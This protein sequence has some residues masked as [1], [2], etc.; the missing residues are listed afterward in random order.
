MSRLTGPEL[1][2]GVVLASGGL[3][4]VLDATIVAVALPYL[5]GTFGATLAAAQWIITAYTLA[6]VATMPLAAGL[7]A[8]WGARRVYLGALAAFAAASAVA[9]A[10]DGLGW[11]IAARAAQGLGGGLM[12]PLGMA[13][14][15]GAVAPE[16]RGRMMAITG[17]PMLAGPILG[18]VL[19]AVLLGTGSWRALFFVT[20]PLALL[21]IAGALAWLP[22]DGA[23]GRRTRLDLAG[24]ML[25][26]PGIVAVAY[27]ISAH[28]APGWV[29]IATAAAGAVLA[30]VFCVRAT[31]RPEP[32]LRIG[33]LGRPGF[34]R[35]AAVLA[36]Y[37][38]PYFGSAVLMPAYV[39]TLRS[40]SPAI[41][42]A[43]M[44]PG[45]IG[46]G[47]SLQIAA[48]LLERLG[49]RLVVG[50]GLGLAIAAGLAQVAVLRPDTPYA[51][52]GLL[53]LLQGAGTGAVMMPTMSS[54]SRDLD[55]PDLASGSALLSLVNTVANGVGTAA[56]SAL[57]TAL[58]GAA[59][60]AAPGPPAQAAI[61]DA[62]RLTQAA[63]LVV[64]ALA[65]AVRLRAPRRPPAILERQ[66]PSAN[67]GQAP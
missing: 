13:I 30:G 19:G 43:L 51:L 15:F 39:Q 65:L 56:V 24:A 11:L 61:V 21:G 17:V 3:M 38:A 53:A 44:V 48:R 2:A 35:G 20:V 57:F 18:P 54:S 64:M 45:A 16:R 41:T 59:L 32:L 66:R 36:L 25:L 58:S 40:D 29:R 9:G 7:A 50:S 62:L 6:M 27:G 26:V 10:A 22:A 63:G 12:T 49:P 1:R 28:D 42:A 37:A 4:A 8:R 67:A 14:G 47:V 46:M 34:G 5:M 52:L 55:G 60:T 33:L 23:A 31:N